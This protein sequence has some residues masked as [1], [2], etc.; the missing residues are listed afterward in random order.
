MIVRRHVPWQLRLAGIVFSVA[1]G[2]VGALWLWQTTIG[3]ASSER[4]SL[5]VELMQ[6]RDRLAA[7]SEERQ[8][9]TA[10][11]NAAESQVKVEQ[12]AAERL[13]S[14][15]KNLETENARLK[16]DLA[17]LESLLPAAGESEGPVAIRRF[18][19]E[20]DDAPNQLRYRALLT[21]SGRTEKEFA[22]FLQLLVSAETD[23]KPATWT[24]PDQAAPATRDGVRVAFKRYQRIEGNFAIPPG[25]TVKSVQ[26]RVLERG[27]VRAQQTALL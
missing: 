2:A 25:S 20:P 5:R 3:T 13:A 7:E 24:W 22:G 11:A 23:G 15:L 27:A 19:V 26:I 12:S 9:L 10:I 6:V 17:Y 4:V 14:Q 18:E 16:T 21:L 8:R 1:V